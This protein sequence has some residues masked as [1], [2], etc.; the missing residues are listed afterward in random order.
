MTKKNDNGERRDRWL[1][2]ITAPT[3]HDLD[4]AVIRIANLVTN[5]SNFMKIRLSYHDDK[6]L[7]YKKMIM[8]ILTN[9]F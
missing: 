3:K 8:D 9:W 2:G 1:K 7:H 6:S 5:F 4:K